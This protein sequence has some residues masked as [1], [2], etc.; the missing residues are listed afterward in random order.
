MLYLFH[1][2][3]KYVIVFLDSFEI[4]INIHKVPYTSSCIYSRNLYNSSLQTSLLSFLFIY[5]FTYLLPSYL[6]PVSCPYMH[7]CAVIHLF[8]GNQVMTKNTE[9]K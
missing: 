6:I 8:M 2:I 9:N 3:S 7:G 1:M 4:F 5:L